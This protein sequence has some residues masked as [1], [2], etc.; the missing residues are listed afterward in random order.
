MLNFTVYEDLIDSSVMKKIL[1]L[2]RKCDI[3]EDF[4]TKCD[5]IYT[6]QDGKKIVACVAF[7]KT[8]FA[9]DRIV[10]RVEHIIFHPDFASK[11]KARSSFLFLLKA[12]ND[13]KERGFAQVW[14]YIGPTKLYMKKMAL[15]FGFNKYS[16][17]TDGE[18]FALQLITK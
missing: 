3:G 9:D 15:R 12:F 17:D 6:W 13:V 11:K 1:A 2:A 16:E 8:K 10:P 18:Y 4:D 7:K 5:L 14:A